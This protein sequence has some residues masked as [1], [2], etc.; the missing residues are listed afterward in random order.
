M[1]DNNDYRKY[2]EERFTGLSAQIK[3]TND[4]QD[5]RLES[6]KKILEDVLRH[7]KETN[8]RVIVLEKNEDWEQVKKNTKVVNEINVIQ[9]YK[10]VFTTG[11]VA[12]FIMAGYTMAKLIFGF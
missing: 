10:K 1:T 4:L 3:S 6:M 2:L 8:G 9:K 12:S 7:V 11:L 5:I